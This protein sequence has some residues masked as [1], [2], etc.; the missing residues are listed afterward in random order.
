VGWLVGEHPHRIREM[1][2]GIEG[3]GGG[4]GERGYHLKCK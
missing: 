2:D 1:G 4:N 3:F